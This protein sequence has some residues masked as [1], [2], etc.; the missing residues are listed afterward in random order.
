[1][2][3]I[4]NDERASVTWKNIKTRRGKDGAARALGYL[5]LLV[6]FGILASIFG[7]IMRG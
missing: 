2:K 3:V 4:S 5:A 1:M 6:M 7:Y